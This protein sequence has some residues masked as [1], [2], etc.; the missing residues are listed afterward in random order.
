TRSSRSVLKFIEKI[1]R[2]Y[3]TTTLIITH[4]EAIADLADTVVRIR[5]GKIASVTENANKR[6]ADE[7]EL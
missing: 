7:I 5:D 6:T 1:N 3:G 4:N 2:R